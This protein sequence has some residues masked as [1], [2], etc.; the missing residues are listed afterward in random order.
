MKSFK[1]SWY[2]YPLYTLAFF[3]VWQLASMVIRFFYEPPLIYYLPPPADAILSI[4]SDW[5][6]IIEGFGASSVRMLSS[7]LLALFIGTPI[8]LVLGHEKQLDRLVSPLL[9]IIDPIPKVVFVPL[10]FAFFG[11]GNSPKIILI[12]LLLVFPV[13]LAARDAAKNLP[14]T[15]LLS[16]RSL[17]ATRS[18]IYRHVVLPACLPAILSTV[19]VSIGFAALGLAI[20]EA[21]QV[22]SRSRG[23]WSYVLNAQHGFQYKDIFAGILAFAML[24][25]VFY[26]IVDVIERLV[27]RWA[28]A[29]S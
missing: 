16:V 20:T 19:R 9:Y 12:T 25:L 7:I 26:I 11:L 29:Q 27:C 24:G 3:L 17:N 28:Y 15:Y 2:F 21:W 6:Q 5:D 13:M 1:S 18:Q 22:S 14:R 4:I 23:L 10:L 8:G